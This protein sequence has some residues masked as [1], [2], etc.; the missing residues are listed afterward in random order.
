MKILIFFA[1]LLPASSWAGNLSCVQDADTY[2][3]TCF[4]PK[5]VTSNGELRATKL[6]SGGPKEV[7]DLG[8]TAVVYCNRQIIE[9]RDRK[10]IVFARNRPT[11]RQSFR[12]WNDICSAESKPDKNLR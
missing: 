11:T 3:T 9:L 6:Y 8:H 2:A 4:D 10:G 12:L 5:K 1:A 7:N